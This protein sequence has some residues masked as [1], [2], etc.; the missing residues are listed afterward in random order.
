MRQN[1]LL[2]AWQS[3]TEKTTHT[4][5]AGLLC[6]WALSYILLP[7]RLPPRGGLRQV[8]ANEMRVAGICGLVPSG[9]HAS[10]TAPFSVLCGCIWE[11]HPRALERAGHKPGGSLSPTQLYDPEPFPPVVKVPRVVAV[12]HHAQVKKLPRHRSAEKSSILN[13]RCQSELPLDHLISSHSWTK[14]KVCK[15]FSRL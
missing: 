14:S 13:P 3:T 10:N 6:P 12:S 2:T 1:W 7:W 5:W 11:S 8:L 4:Y 15:Y 9:R